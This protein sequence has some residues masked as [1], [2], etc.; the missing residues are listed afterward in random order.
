MR[1][2]Q[3]KRIA[4]TLLGVFVLLTAVATV[5]RSDALFNAAIVALVAMAVIEIAFNRCPHCRA[6]VGRAG[7][8]YCSRCGQSLEE[9]P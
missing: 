5:I 7:G 2:A 4:L 9:D 8:K 3:A 6:Y 1:R